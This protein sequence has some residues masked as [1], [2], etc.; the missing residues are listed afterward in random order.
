MGT[1]LAM[2]SELLSIYHFMA[3]AFKVPFTLAQSLEPLIVS[4]YNQLTSRIGDSLKD[5]E[6]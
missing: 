4:N 3:A 2:I 6:H 5:F 1:S